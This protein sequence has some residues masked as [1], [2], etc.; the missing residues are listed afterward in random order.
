MGILE[1]ELVLLLE[2]V[3]ASLGRIGRS[4]AGEL[5]L[6]LLESLDYHFYDAS[7]VIPRFISLVISNHPSYLPS[8]CSFYYLSHHPLC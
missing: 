1:E 3:A 5:V 8:C 7:Y 4:R 2:P 6:Q